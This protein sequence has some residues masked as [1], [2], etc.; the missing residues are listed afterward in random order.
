MK[1][2]GS[3]VGRALSDLFEMKHLFNQFVPSGLAY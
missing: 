3:P 1:Q 2:K